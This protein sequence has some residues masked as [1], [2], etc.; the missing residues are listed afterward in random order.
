MKSE[1]PGLGWNKQGARGAASGEGA[2]PECVRA[3][4]AAATE[5]LCHG[6]L[7]PQPASPL[8]QLWAWRWSLGSLQTHQWY[9]ALRADFTRRLWKALP[10][11]RKHTLCGVQVMKNRHAL[12]WRVLLCWAPGGSATNST[13]R[14]RV[15]PGSAQSVFYLCLQYNTKARIFETSTATWPEV[16]KVS[17][18]ELDYFTFFFSFCFIY[19][20]SKVHSINLAS[21]LLFN[22]K[23]ETSLVLALC[24]Q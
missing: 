24:I 17:C 14:L 3:G 11:V 18:V 15:L 6:V 4:S 23:N 8:S 20:Q 21:Y 1:E 22:L 19:K 10:D 13:E 7:A 12:G 2:H 9:L 16:S 5:R